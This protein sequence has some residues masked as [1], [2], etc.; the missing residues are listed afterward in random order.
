V[1]GEGDD[2]FLMHEKK[3]E[4]MDDVAM[5]SLGAS[6]YP[7]VC[8]NIPPF[9]N[10]RTVGSGAQQSRHCRRSP[11]VSFSGEKSIALQT[12]LAGGLEPFNFDE[13]ASTWT[14]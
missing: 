2:V 8:I 11:L 5:T 1:R 6:H 9:V 7:P 13:D 3:E 10:G 12:R 14:L 4:L